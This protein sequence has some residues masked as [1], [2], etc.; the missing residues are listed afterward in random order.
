MVRGKQ[1]RSSTL[2][3]FK[4]Q[5]VL[6]IID[7]SGEREREEGRERGMTFVPRDIPDPITHRCSLHSPH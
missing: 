1:R 6:Q 5:I 3:P 4:L 2:A 7:R